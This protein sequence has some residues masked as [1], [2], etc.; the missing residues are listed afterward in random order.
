[1]KKIILTVEGMHCEG[2]ENRI[3]NSLELLEGVES[4]TCSYQEKQV[5]IN[6]K[7]DFDLGVIKEQI[8]DLGFEVTSKI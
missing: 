7:E 6:L 5:E 4:V 1:M 2:C 3:K 8:E